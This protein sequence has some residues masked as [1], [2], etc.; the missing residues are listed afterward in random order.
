MVG[1]SEQLSFQEV[2]EPKKMPLGKCVQAS[3]RLARHPPQWASSAL[4]EYGQGEASVT[5]RY[6]T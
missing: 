5:L 3:G 1:T 4:Q 6:T 2:G